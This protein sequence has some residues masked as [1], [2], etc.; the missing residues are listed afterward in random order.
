MRFIFL[1]LVFSYTLIQLLIFVAFFGPLV[2]VHWGKDTHHIKLHVQIN[3]YS[4]Y[5]II[6]HVAVTKDFGS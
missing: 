5:V 1:A 3:S 6:G 4:S 2:L